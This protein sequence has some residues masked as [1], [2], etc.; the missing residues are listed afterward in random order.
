[1]GCL[2]LGPSRWQPPS[3]GRSVRCW[4]LSPRTV[5][6]GRSC[7]HSPRVRRMRPPQNETSRRG[8]LRHVAPGIKLTAVLG[9]ITLTALLPR[10][11]DIL[12]AIPAV[13][14][15]L[16]WILSRMPLVY[17]FRRILIAEFFIIGIGLLS[18][19]VPASRP[20]FLAALIK[21]N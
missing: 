3:P 19:L 12:Y 21:S 6:P 9:I 11:P 4:L 13:L 2:L 7:P 17:T 14:L 20:I 15:T 8:I 10:R 18:L 1:T 5:W 16:I